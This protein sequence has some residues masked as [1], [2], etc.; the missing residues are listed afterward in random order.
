MKLIILLVVLG[1]E[2][3]LGVGETL[4]RFSC[5]NP[6]LNWMDGMLGKQAW[7]NGL[8]GALLTILPIPIVVTLV[9]ALFTHSLHGTQGLMGLIL[10]SF[11]L[12][13]ALGPRDLYRQVS[14]YIGEP[15]KET[16]TP[17]AEIESQL[18]DGASSAEPH[19]VTKSIFWQA[20]QSL[21]GSLFWFM[22]FGVFGA[23][24]YRCA[25]LLR[26]ASSQ[27]DSPFSNQYI[28][29]QQIQNVLDWIPVRV[30]TLFF[31]LVG[32]F[33][34]SF[35][36]WLENLLS[37]LS[38]SRRFISEG[39]LIALG[40]TKSEKPSHSTEECRAALSLIDRALIIFL[41][42]VALFIFGSWV[43]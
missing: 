40:L 39:G 13:Y 3:Y 33:N 38:N 20:N 6:Y 7:F 23:L 35:S 15:G 27:G 31:A 37:G 16:A 10:G 43:Y 9:C 32:Q 42:I 11:V 25:V 34:A 36:Y 22:L 5:F 24:F 14:G 8:V 2:R 1:L 17:A 26:Q 12:F 28:A 21:F 18:L 30:F 4:K 29:A 41:A 19:A